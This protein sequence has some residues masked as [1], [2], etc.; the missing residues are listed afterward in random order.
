MS[1]ADAERRATLACFRTSGIAFQALYVPRVGDPV[2][3][4][5]ILEEEPVVNGEAPV[6][7]QETR[8]LA[9]LLVSDVPS[10]KRG[11][12]LLLVDGVTSMTLQPDGSILTFSADGQSLLLGS[13]GGYRIED[14]IRGNALELTCTLVPG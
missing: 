8:T 6:Q 7:V 14:K 1:F 10:P 13:S 4:T 3:T 5:A 9:R 2:T 12:R 11:D